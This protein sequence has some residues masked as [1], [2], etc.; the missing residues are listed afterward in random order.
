MQISFLFT[1]KKSVLCSKIK[2]R[3]YPPQNMISYISD[4]RAGVF[5]T[6]KNMAMSQQMVDF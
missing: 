2:T 5:F 3:P 6:L 4:K 1:Y